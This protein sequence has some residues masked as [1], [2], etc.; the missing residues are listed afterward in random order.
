MDLDTNLIC[1]NI[2]MPTEVLEGTFPWRT[3]PW[4]NVFFF[5]VCVC[6]CTNASTGTGLQHSTFRH[7]M[8]RSVTS[9][10]RTPRSATHTVLIGAQGLCAPITLRYPLSTGDVHTQHKGWLLMSHTMA[11]IIFGLS[12]WIELRLLVC[13]QK[14]NIS[15]LTSSGLSVPWGPLQSLFYLFLQLVWATSN[16]I[17]CAINVCYNMNVWGMIWAKAVYL[18]C[19]YS[20]P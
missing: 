2:W 9:V 7:G 18:V 3:M 16:R 11:C 14:P 1:R 10:T 12:G 4:I 5:C 20:P 17:G 19:N 8:T 6:Y 13:F 15:V